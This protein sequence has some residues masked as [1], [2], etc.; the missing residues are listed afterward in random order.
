[1]RGAVAGERVVWAWALWAL[2][3]C[4]CAG[5][6]VATLDQW[7][8]Q[9]EGD[10]PVRVQLPARLDRSVIPR[11]VRHFTLST[12]VELPASARGQ[13]LELVIPDLAG[14][15]LLSV[16][17]ATSTLP[18]GVST[19]GAI[20]HGPYVWPIS[21]AATSDGAIELRLELENRWTQ[22]SWV[23]TVPRLVTTGSGANSTRLQTVVNVL[24]SAC[25]LVALFQIGLTSLGV[26]LVD[27]RR[28]AYGYFAI[29]ALTATCY[30]LYVLGFADRIVGIF[31][32]PLVMASLTIAIAVSI[33]FT[34]GFFDLPAPSRRW[35]QFAVVTCA[36]TAVFSG[37]FA[38]TRVAA[39]ATILYLTVAIAYQVSVCIRLV[40]SH[41]DRPGAIFLLVAWIGLALSAMPDMLAWLGLADVL[42]GARTGSAGLA[43]YPLWLSLLLS[44]RHIKSLNRADQLNVELGSRVELLE[45][46]GAEI[47]QLNAELRH[48]IAERS[49]QIFAALALAGQGRDVAPEL[50]A[51]TLVQDRYRVV[52]HLGAGGMGAVYEVERVSDGRRLAL[53]VARELNGVALARLAR[54][55][56]IACRVTHANVVSVFDVDVAT[57]GFLYMV[58]EL[59]QG[60]SLSKFRDRFGDASWA[61]PILAQVADGLAA[62]HAVEVVHR[63]LKPANVLITEVNGQAPLAK[64]SDF[65]ISL[66]SSHTWPRPFAALDLDSEEE[67]RNLATPKSGVSQRTV[68]LAPAE[69]RGGADRGAAPSLTQTGMLPGTPAYIA[70]ELVNGREHVTPAADIFSF[71]VI[72]FEMLSRTRPFSEPPALS[73]LEARKPPTAA[74]LATI[75]TAGPP[76]LM[77]LID[78]ALALDPRRRPTATA[79]AQALR[80]GMSWSLDQNTA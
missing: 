31:A 17:G 40:R 54:E 7:T 30:P 80:R 70:P 25:A 13:P 34:H 4:G 66:H 63:D 60:Q 79:L 28:H 2:T 5:A 38:A 20:Q 62:L 50:A 43:F 45:R 61:M 73:L 26:Y 1:M 57:D 44:R 14:V 68:Q 22:S 71:G 52:G 65:G 53:K 55:A 69:R 16:D 18:I 47:E 24:F 3:L 58:M 21:A 49:S 46:R 11:R 10:A 78:D 72:A 35:A 29:Q 42:E 74:P 67:T 33:Y 15:P 56:Q 77:R 36:I 59:V 32:S 51:G 76:D 9:A 23:T 12:H 41:H 39:P 8:V 6:P 75:W 37:P 19:S 27:R 48:Q 64:I